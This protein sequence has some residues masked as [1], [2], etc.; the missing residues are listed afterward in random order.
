METTEDY[1]TAYLVAVDVTVKFYSLLSY[2]YYYLQALEMDVAVTEAKEQQS[3]NIT[4]SY[5]I[6]MHKIY[7]FLNITKI[8]H[9]CKFCEFY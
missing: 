5:A 8:L 9:F 3:K 2:S 4:K 7:F 6:K 1:S